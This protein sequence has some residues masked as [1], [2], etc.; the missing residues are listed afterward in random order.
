MKIWIV[1]HYA[2]PDSDPGGTRHF[3]FARRLRAMG[4]EPAIIA[5]SFSHFGA[6]ERFP[7]SIDPSKVEELAGVPFLWIHASPYNGNSGGRVKNMLE[8][9]RGV[10]AQAPKKLFRPD[11]IIGSNAH[12]FAVLAASQMAKRFRVPFVF[13]VR[14]LWP[15]SLVDLA[16]YP[17]NGPVVRVLSGLEKHLYKKA[18]KIITLL[19]ESGEYIE[20][21]GGDGKVV[22]IPNG[23]DLD[24]V[25]EQMPPI[26]DG[27]F[28]A[29]YAGS[30]GPANG[31]DVLLDAA[32]LAPSVQF[33]LIGQGSEKSRL[34]GRVEKEGIKNVRF[35][36][37]VPKSQIRRVG[38]KGSCRFDAAKNLS[39]PPLG[40]QPEQ[41][42]GLH[43]GWPPDCGGTHRAHQS[44][45]GSPRG[46]HDPAGRPG[47]ARK[48]RDQAKQ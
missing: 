48:R 30:H 25:P 46:P 1:N 20:A 10:K 28:T 40:T 18:T 22:W 6:Q 3:S 5:S 12:L 14:D 11:V 24:Y 43:G 29:L 16:G 19:K 13:E 17:R 35:E 27:P 37:P 26:P 34:I 39:R 33:C 32:K 8:F 9:Y 4:H 31:L 7:G 15:E 45:R 21:R 36:D 38:G 42:V 47:A 23:I 44:R 2:V 41:D